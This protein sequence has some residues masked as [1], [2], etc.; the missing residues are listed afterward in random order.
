[1]ETI[2]EV[3]IQNKTAPIPSGKKDESF[4]YMSGTS[5][6]SNWVPEVE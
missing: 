2:P 3:S 5:S 6:E 4:D 1:M